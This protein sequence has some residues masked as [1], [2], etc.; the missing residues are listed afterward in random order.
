MWAHA[1]G[2]PE[3][4]AYE[5]EPEKPTSLPAATYKNVRTVG[6]ATDS[7]RPKKGSCPDGPGAT[8][9]SPE[10]ALTLAAR[11]FPVAEATGGRCPRLE[12]LEF[13]LLNRRPSF[14]APDWVD[15][16]FRTFSLRGKGLEDGH[17]G[18]AGNHTAPAAGLP[19]H[20]IGPCPSPCE[21]RL[22]GFTPAG[23]AIFA[24]KYELSAADVGW[25]G[26][27]KEI[28]ARSPKEDIVAKLM[29]TAFLIGLAVTWRPDAA[30]GQYSWSGFSVSLGF[31]TGGA[32]FGLGAS[33]T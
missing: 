9:P 33:Y 32:G 19:C 1:Y 27:C 16:N 15:P 24:K 8:R 18:I 11:A 28:G 26:L 13:G 7:C 14:R 21:D 25:H 29:R 30:A 2:G 12:R 22:T 10:P 5:K 31:G 4:A 17:A 20:V 3:T 23:V 6:W